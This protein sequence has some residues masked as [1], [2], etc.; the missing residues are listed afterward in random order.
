MNTIKDLLNETKSDKQSGHRFGFFYDM[1]FATAY[2]Q[3]GSKPLRVLEIGVSEFG[4]GSLRAYAQSDLTEHAVGLDIK[5]YVGEL[6]DNM[7]FYH[8]SAYS[9]ETIQF[10]AEKEEKFDIIIDDGSHQEADQKFFLEQ[11]MVLLNDDGF[12]ICEDITSLEMINAADADDNAFIFDGWGNMGLKLATVTDPRLYTH[13]ERIIVRSKSAL[14]DGVKHENK[15]HIV[16]LPVQ[17]FRKYDRGNTELAITIPMFHPG[18]D[19]MYDTKKFQDVHVKG[20]IWAGMSMIHNTDLGENGVPLYFHIEDKV[21]NDA[22]VVMHEFGVPTAWCRKM[23][24]P[25]PTIALTTR[26]AMF[27]K[28]LMALLDTDLD[29]DILM[30]VDSDLFTCPMQ[31]KFQIYEKLTMPLLKHQPAMTYFRR[32]NMDYGKWISFVVGSAPAAMPLWGKEPLNVVEQTG[33]AALGLERALE[34]DLPATAIVNRFFCEP[35]LMTMPRNHPVREFAKTLIPQSYTQNYALGMWAETNSQFVELDSLL[36]IPTYDW[37]RDFLRSARGESCF[38][39]IRVSRGRSEK[40]S[41]A[42]LI[43]QYWDRFFESVSRYV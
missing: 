37:E 33:Y 14:T 23:T 32:G 15:P 1:I 12:L 22:M 11:Y 35:Y 40:L 42:S 5:E 41:C 2:L 9:K 26:K 16:N 29:P 19:D 34:K 38:S 17:Q 31:D 24:L 4:D 28:S 36:G 20:A 10:L 18:R 30:W 6:L 8:K 39:H 7:T 25:E 13:G 27:S 21:W 3:K 43:H